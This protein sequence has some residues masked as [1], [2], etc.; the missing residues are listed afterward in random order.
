MANEPVLLSPGQVL[1]IACVKQWL[2]SVGD[3]SDAV[4]PA[5]IQRAL[6]GICREVDHLV[7]HHDSEEAELTVRNLEQA[8]LDGSPMV[9]W[10]NLP[11]VDFLGFKLF[12]P[13]LEQEAAL[14]AV[15]GGLSMESSRVPRDTFA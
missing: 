14:G 15:L 7:L 9:F 11:P 8:V 10:G 13:S 1:S 6:D 2:H 4:P 5:I 3:V 12:K